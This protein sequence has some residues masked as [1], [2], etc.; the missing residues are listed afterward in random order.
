[1]RKEGYE[2]GRL[3]GRGARRK[4]ALRKERKIQGG[5]DKRE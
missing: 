5:K 4:G 1:M 3:G 2:E